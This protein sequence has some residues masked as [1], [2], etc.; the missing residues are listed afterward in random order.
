MKK[1]SSCGRDAGRKDS[2]PAVQ[3]QPAAFAVAVR[4]ERDAFQRDVV[5]LSRVPKDVAEDARLLITRL[6][7]GEHFQALG[8]KMINRRKKY[9]SVPIGRRWRLVC[10]R[11][12]GAVQPRRIL[13]HSDYN[14]WLAQV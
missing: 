13:S 9:V 3:N 8:G 7:G 10:E 6:L 11:D 2:R 14:K 5:D 1:R 12:R 4:P